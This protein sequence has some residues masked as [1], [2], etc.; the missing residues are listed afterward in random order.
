ML[1]I[2][3]PVYSRGF[4]NFGSAVITFS[5]IISCFRFSAR[6][7]VRFFLVTILMVSRGVG[8]L[9]PEEHAIV[10][11]I[12]GRQSEMIALLEQSVRIDSATENHAGVHAVAEL[13]GEQLKQAGLTSRW[14][15]LPVETQRAGHLF[16][17]RTGSRGKRV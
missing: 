1:Q 9:S 6:W 13:F 17:E 16:A 7:V 3:S 15:P 10:D 4:E 11:W 12:S 5:M 8:A 14:I 2:K